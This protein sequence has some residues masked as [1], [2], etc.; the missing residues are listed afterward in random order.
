MFSLCILLHIYIFLL[1]VI[2]QFFHHFIACPL[3]IDTF[4]LF[5]HSPFRLFYLYLWQ[6]FITSAIGLREKQ[7]QY[8]P[9]ILS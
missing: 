4:S 8:L 7:S 9:L 1:P 5:C 2:S 3:G 6:K